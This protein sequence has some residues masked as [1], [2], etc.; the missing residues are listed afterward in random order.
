MSTTQRS[1]A[2]HIDIVMQELSAVLESCAEV[3]GQFSFGAADDWSEMLAQLSPSPG[4]KPG[5]SL[6]PVK[7]P[8]VHTAVPVSPAVQSPGAEISTVGPKPPPPPG[9]PPPPAVKLSGSEAGQEVGRLPLLAP[10]PPPPPKVAGSK[11]PA[12]TPPPPGGA[13]SSLTPTQGTPAS[14]HQIPSTPNLPTPSAEF[15]VLHWDILQPHV[16][17]RAPETIWTGPLVGA[18][19]LQL[20]DLDKIELFT[21]PPA[22]AALGKAFTSADGRTRLLDTSSSNNILITFKD[23]TPEC[24]AKAL[25]NLDTKNLTYSTVLQCQALLAKSQTLEVV[26]Q[27]AEDN[28]PSKLGT[29]EAFVYALVSLPDVR[30]RLDVLR[31]HHFFE[32]DLPKKSKPWKRLLHQLLMA[33]NA[34]NM[35]RPG[36]KAARGFKL[37][38]LPR[39]A[40][41]SHIHRTGDKAWSLLDVVVEAIELELTGD[42]AWSL[43]D[44]VVEA[45]ELD[46]PRHIDE[47]LELEALLT[48]VKEVDLRILTNEVQELSSETK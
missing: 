32:E 28:D 39:F 46:C 30:L 8:G 44:V 9:P 24:M 23:T 25:Q 27:W 22:T 7:F 33:G 4:P 35:R 45:I 2:P 38:S 42:K 1:D 6:A 12:G 17:D 40:D 13:S 31:L 41:M 18:H 16:L 26:M 43:L 11:G 47:L 3:V 48:N 21:R 37:S 15:K 34:I 36:G 5:L 19:H 20:V 10:P 29:A 14:S